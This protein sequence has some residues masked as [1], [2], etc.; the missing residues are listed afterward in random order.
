MTGSRLPVVAIVASAGGL[1]AIIRVF[2]PFPADLPCAIIVALH[3]QPG[4][5]SE[6]AAILQRHTALTVVDAG[7]GAVLRRGFAF[8][9]PS[10]RHLLVLADDRLALVETGD[11][12]PE[13]PS[14]DLLLATLAVTCGP[15]A[16]AV[17]LSGFGHDAQVGVRAVA[18][19]GGMV[20]AQSPESSR[21][22]AMPAAAIATGR[23]NEVVDVDEISAAIIRR[24]A[25]PPTRRSDADGQTE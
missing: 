17:V 20:I 25:R 18:R 4:R 8:V 3:Q 23:V 21:F 7:D 22:A 5:V 13:R 16:L 19:C 9:V 14:G 11:L 10:S 24:L 15:R 1:D 12:P 6:L 2:A